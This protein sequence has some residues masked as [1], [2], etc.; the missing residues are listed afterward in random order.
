M[1]AH[2]T[3]EDLV[4]VNPHNPAGSLPVFRWRQ[5][6][7]GLATRR[8]LREM[9]LRPGGQEPAARIECRGGKRFAWLYRT[10]LAKPK[11]PMT[12]AKESRARQGDGLLVRRAPAPAAGA[13]STASRSRPWARAWRWPRRHARRPRTPTPLPRPRTCWPPDPRG[14]LMQATVPPPSPPYSD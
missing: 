11:R 7:P 13:T 10:D 2:D 4:D 8:Q 5:A 1:H 14:P 6:G 9:G 3:D 12:L